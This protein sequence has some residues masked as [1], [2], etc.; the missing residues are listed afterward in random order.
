MSLTP[1]PQKKNRQKKPQTLYFVLSFFFSNM[2][3]YILH[4]T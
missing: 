3:Q 2:E 1:T 4:F